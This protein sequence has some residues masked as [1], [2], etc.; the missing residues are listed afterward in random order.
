M[1]YIARRSEFM[2]D[3]PPAAGRTAEQPIVLDVER[4][5]IQGEGARLRNGKPAA[6]VE[7][8]D[9][10]PAWAIGNYSLVRQL[11][12]DPRVSRNARLHWSAWKLGEIPKNWPLRLWAE[13]EHVGTAYGGDDRRLRSLMSGALTARRTA[14]LRQQIADITASLPDEI[15]AHP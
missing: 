9:R 2:S 4:T 15:Q 8:P 5:Y 3:A 7:L 11:L 6:R 10:V 1:Q 14:A 12:A 13:I